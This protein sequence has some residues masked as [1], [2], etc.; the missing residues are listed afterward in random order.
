MCWAN[1][2]LDTQR[3]LL[4]ALLK[5][6]LT[7]HT[8]LQPVSHTFPV[9]SYVAGDAHWQATQSHNASEHILRLFV[10]S[11]IDWHSLLQ[12]NPFDFS[13]IIALITTQCAG[14]ASVQTT[15]HIINHFDMDLCLVAVAALPNQFLECCIGSHNPQ[16]I[17]MHEALCAVQEK[18]MS[19]T[20]SVPS[21]I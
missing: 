9:A 20:Q 16:G 11:R 2:A 15:E 6:C 7:S 10:N 18:Q 21:S 13:Q 5:P 3:F 17:M 8:M 12:H 4:Q 19:R 1:I 14:G